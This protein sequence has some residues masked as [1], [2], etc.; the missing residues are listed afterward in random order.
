MMQEM[1]SFLEKCS[2]DGWDA[3]LPALRERV[4][5]AEG[6]LLP[7]ERVREVEAAVQR[8]DDVILRCV[9]NDPEKGLELEWVVDKL[10]AV[11]HLSREGVCHRQR[12]CLFMSSQLL[13]LQR[14][15][16]S[17]EA[18]LKEEGARD[19]IGA[20]MRWEETATPMAAE[21]GWGKEKLLSMLDEASKLVTTFKALETTT[22]MAELERKIQALRQISGGDVEAR[23]WDVGLGESAGWDEVL[24][25]AKLSL[26]D[27]EKFDGEV[28]EQHIQS[29]E[30]ARSCV[31]C[32]GKDTV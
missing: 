26:L 31:G 12:V 16:G 21:D 10:S 29:L 19:L 2:E 18:I 28:L 15:G 23:S 20:L 17:A 27:K 32:L 9:G 7:P 25:Q 24:A 14:L 5:E 13:Q 8:F 4:S 1:Q 22:S 3:G 6:V 30:K 11:A